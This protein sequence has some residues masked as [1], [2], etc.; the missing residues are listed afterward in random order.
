[1]PTIA[2]GSSPFRSMI[3]CAT[4]TRVRLRSSR[5]RTAWLKAARPFLASPDRVKG[6]VEASLTPGRTS[7][8]AML[9]EA[10]RDRLSSLG[11]GHL[12]HVEVA[13]HDRR[14]E[15]RLRFLL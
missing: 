8:L 4:R 9:P 12:D 3:S 2:I 15:H 6:T 11:I 13:R 14:L 7:S 5:S 1:M 10:H